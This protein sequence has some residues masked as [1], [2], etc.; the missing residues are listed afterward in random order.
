[1]HSVQIQYQSGEVR[2]DETKYRRSADGW[3]QV[4]SPALVD[5]VIAYFKAKS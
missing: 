5:R 1:L 3:Q 4:I 2:E